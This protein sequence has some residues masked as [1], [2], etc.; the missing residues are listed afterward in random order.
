MVS[1]SPDRWAGTCSRSGSLSTGATAS[2]CV[3]YGRVCLEVTSADRMDGG[4]A[5]TTEGDGPQ[6]APPGPGVGSQAGRVC[7]RRDSFRLTAHPVRLHIVQVQRS[8]S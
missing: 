7:L 6:G 4:A 3:D 8:L 1:P 2:S 5:L